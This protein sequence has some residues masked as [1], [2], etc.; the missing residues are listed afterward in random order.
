MLPADDTSM[1]RTST[2]LPFYVM[3]FS[4]LKFSIDNGRKLDEQP[5]SCLTWIHHALERNRVIR[6]PSICKYMSMTG[7]LI[8]GEES[9]VKNYLF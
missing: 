4:H 3:Y 5:L 8:F 2:I 9:S 6:I 7:I 1:Q